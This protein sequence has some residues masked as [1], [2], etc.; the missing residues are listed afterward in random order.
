M[1]GGDDVGYRTPHH[2]TT[3]PSLSV[4]NITA[5][6]GAGRATG[7]VVRGAAK[8]ATARRLSTQVSYTSQLTR[9]MFVPCS[10]RESFDS[11]SGLLR[12]FV[13][14]M[15]ALSIHIPPFEDTADHQRIHD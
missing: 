8:S 9:S 13:S 5:C 14:P 15:A 2:E 1:R 7:S 6:E 11:S 10:T 4:I 12:G 3:A